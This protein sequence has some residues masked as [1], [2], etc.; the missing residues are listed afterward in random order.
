MLVDGV[1][2]TGEYLEVPDLACAWFVHEVANGHAAWEQ[3]AIR[4]MREYR[5]AV[6]PLSHW[7]DPHY[8]EEERDRISAARVAIDEFLGED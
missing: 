3:D 7:V 1:Q 4:L 6:S 2:R 8:S 5:A